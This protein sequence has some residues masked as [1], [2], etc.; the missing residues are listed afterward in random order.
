MSHNGSYGNP[1]LLDLFC[2][3]GGA[4]DGYHRA[5]FH[6]VGVDVEDQPRYP[7]DLLTADAVRVLTEMPRF[8]DTFDAF[9]AS[10]PCQAHSDLQKQSKREY[11]DFIVP[12][13]EALDRIGKPY[14]I[15]NV[16]GAPLEDPVLLCGTMFPSLRVIRHR[17]F[18]TNWP[19]R[20]RQ[21]QGAL[22]PAQPGR[23]LRPGH[24]R[25]QL[26][27]RKQA[28]GDGHAV[29]DREGLQRGDSARLH[30]MDRDAAPSAPRA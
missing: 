11:P 22:R 16:E 29:D 2:C 24:G 23:E 21:A 27:G 9:H 10:P 18:E 17:L 7:F 20:A 5:G 6:V 8:V 14:V 28:R 13:R 26:H 19:L 25:R 15:E 1:R 12:V 4:G 30:G 3:E